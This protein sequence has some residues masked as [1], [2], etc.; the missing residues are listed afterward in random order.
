MRNNNT[1]V[2]LQV[3]DI[4]GRQG[5]RPLG[6]PQILRQLEAPGQAAVEELFVLDDAQPS[7]KRQFGSNFPPSRP[8]R[9]F[10]RQLEEHRLH[11]SAM[12]ARLLVGGG[13]D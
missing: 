8:C 5:S 10:P 6:I 7:V 13:V 4:R 12:N 3:M 2:L 11:L 1:Y 9:L